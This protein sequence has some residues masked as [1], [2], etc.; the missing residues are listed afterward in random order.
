[1]FSSLVG[2]CLAAILPSALATVYVSLTTIP[3]PF[4]LILSKITAPTAATSWP[5]GLPATIKWQDDGNN[6]TLAA[7]GPASISLAVGSPETQ[8]CHY[9]ASLCS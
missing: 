7:F 6:P 5:A 9:P 2:L 8:V 4:E 1:M 3:S